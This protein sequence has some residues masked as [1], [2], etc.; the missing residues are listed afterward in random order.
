[1]SARKCDDCSKNDATFLTRR[2]KKSPFKVVCNE[3][4]TKYIKL[5]GIVSYH[6]SSKDD[7]D[8]LQQKI[9]NKRIE[10]VK[11]EKKAKKVTRQKRK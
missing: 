6:P 9:E 4:S 11:Q 5:G 2:T 10:E 7:I 1:M 3:C 8:R